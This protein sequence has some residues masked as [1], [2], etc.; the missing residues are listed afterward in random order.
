LLHCSRDPLT[1]R[2]PLHNI[3]QPG[4]FYFN[5]ERDNLSVAG[6]IP[7]CESSLELFG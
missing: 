5:A 6:A 2:R 1:E 4:P 3:M 7:A